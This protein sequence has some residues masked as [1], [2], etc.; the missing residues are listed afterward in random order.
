MHEFSVTESLLALALEKAGQAGAGR[1]TR[2]NLVLGEM[3]GVVGECVQ[4]YFEALSRDT[5]AGDWVGHTWMPLD[6]LAAYARVI[7]WNNTGA[8]FGLLPSAGLILLSAWANAAELTPPLSSPLATSSMPGD[9]SATLPADAATPSKS[10]VSF[11]LTPEPCLLVA[12]RPSSAAF[13]SPIACLAP[14]A[15]PS[16]F[17]SV[18]SSS[19]IRARLHAVLESSDIYA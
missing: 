14:L 4:F 7:N 16:I 19:A 15:S 6:W 5:I 11:S 1:V 9:D 10:A 2:I 8:A 12:S 18:F 17:S 13:A 3:S